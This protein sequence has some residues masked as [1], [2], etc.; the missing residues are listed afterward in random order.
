MLG[1]LLQLLNLFCRQSCN[2]G[3]VSKVY[4]FDLHLLGIANFLLSL[5]FAFCSGEDIAEVPEYFQALLV[6]RLSHI[7]ELDNLYF[8]SKPLNITTPQSPLPS[9]L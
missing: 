9:I 4:A 6:F 2:I 5:A 3:N 1:Y 7:S 8:Q